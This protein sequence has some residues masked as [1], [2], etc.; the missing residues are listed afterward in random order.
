M[1]FTVIKNCTKRSPMPKD[2][3]QMGNTWFHHDAKAVEG[4]LDRP[5]VEG[6]QILN[7]CPNCGYEFFTTVGRRVT[8]KEIQA[9]IADLRK[10]GWNPDA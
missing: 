2:R 5:L 3:D 10:R 8:L 4:Q 7:H 1:S 6:M 9:D